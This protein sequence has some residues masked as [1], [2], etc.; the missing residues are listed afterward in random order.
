MVGTR[1]PK[2]LSLPRCALY[3]RQV[4]R[5]CKFRPS[6]LTT[7]TQTFDPFLYVCSPRAIAEQGAERAVPPQPISGACL[8]TE[9]GRR[10][11]YYQA[12][13]ASSHTGAQGGGDRV[14]CVTVRPARHPGVLGV[15]GRPDFSRF[16][17]RPERPHFSNFGPPAERIPFCENSPQGGKNWVFV[18]KLSTI[19][20]DL[21]TKTGVRTLFSRHGARRPT[22]AC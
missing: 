12:A 4:G 16:D 1:R 6:P 15:R 17:P 22:L 14:A 18:D 5:P 2:L 8:H 10:G 20:D 7:E 19:V 13:R 11:A 3:A 9:R 21:S